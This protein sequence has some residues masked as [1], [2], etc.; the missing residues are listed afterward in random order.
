MRR[1][2]ILLV[3]DNSEDEF[4]VKRAFNRTRL[5]VEIVV[6][7][8]GR[9]ALD[10][11]LGTGSFAERRFEIL[12]DLVLLDLDLPKINGLSVLRSIRSEPRTRLVPVVIF[13][14]SAD[15]QNRLTAYELGANS[16][17]VKPAET[18]E[19]Q[20]VVQDLCRYWLS[21]NSPLHRAP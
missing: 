6:A 5:P 14:A 13:T 11:L 8:D 7:K 16:Y 15:E 2:T 18:P 4:L 12:P 1:K 19:L 3:E 17:V 21:L 10:F 20:T 9:E